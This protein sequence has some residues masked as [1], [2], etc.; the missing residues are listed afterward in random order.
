[1]RNILRWI[2]KIFIFKSALSEDDTCPDGMTIDNSSGECIDIN[3]CEIA[4]ACGHGG[5][6]RNT[7]GGFKVD[8]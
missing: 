5:W 2:T 8:I 1:M 6:C 3:E 4:D 7:N